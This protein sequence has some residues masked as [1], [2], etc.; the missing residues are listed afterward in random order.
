MRLGGKILAFATLFSIIFFILHATDATRTVVRD[1]M[2]DLGGIP[3]LYSAVCLIFS[4]LAGFVIQHEWD[5]WNDFL[6]AIKGEVS[7]VRT[8]WLWSQHVPH[9]RTK[10]QEAIRQYVTV[11]IQN[12]WRPQRWAGARL[13]ARLSLPYRKKPPDSFSIRNSE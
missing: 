8:L 13:P 3:W 4:I 6:D 10:L 1:D 5:Q 7:S 2:D 9:L 12:E 11:T